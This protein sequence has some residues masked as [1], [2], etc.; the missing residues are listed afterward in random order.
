MEDV[1]LNSIVLSVITE[2]DTKA[3]K[4]VAGVRAVGNQKIRRL[5]H[6]AYEQGAVLTNVD[7]AQLINVHRNTI[8]NRISAIEEDEE[9]LTNSEHRPRY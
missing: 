3:S 2:E 8:G 4:N 5:C 7:L 9:A 6:E 1:P